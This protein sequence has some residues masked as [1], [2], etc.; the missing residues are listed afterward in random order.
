LSTY[1][2]YL[3][4]AGSIFDNTVKS[5][6]G[7]AELRAFTFAKYLVTKGDKVFF[8]VNELSQQ[9]IIKDGVTATT[10]SYNQ[11]KK[12]GLV[13]KIKHRFLYYSKFK[14]LIRYEDFLKNIEAFKIYPDYIFVFGLTGNALTAS[15]IC[16]VTKSKLVTFI[17][18]DEDVNFEK[19]SK[20]YTKL[21][22]SLELAFEVINNSAKIFV[23]NIYQKESLRYIFN[24]PSVLLL[25]PIEI[26]TNFS[27][28]SKEFI[29][30]V[31]KSSWYKNPLL[32]IEVANEFKEYKF[33]LICNRTNEN[34]FEQINNKMPRNCELLEQ[35]S[36]EEVEEY[37]ARC[38]FFINTSEFEG[39]P[40]T[41]LQAAKYGKPIVSFKVNPNNVIS[42]NN[43]GFFA[44]G[45]K[46]QLNKMIATL[47]SDIEIYNTM[48]KN[49]LCYIKKHD[50]NSVGR[51]LQEHLNAL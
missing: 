43:C 45:N 42:D 13:Q 34:V 24:S 23:Q 15:K 26:T 32:M 38:I 49:S 36:V 12:I 4:D 19:A 18:S 22:T 44:N 7:G 41:F 28:N 47:L 14:N 10:I 37:F 1:L 2:F 40:N 35:V 46:E 16:F 6:I 8:V 27:S 31:G 11:K 51:T 21:N 48:S 3:P 25:N 20:K 9:Q 29:L 17:A 30:W 5:A 33:L 39:F 50:V